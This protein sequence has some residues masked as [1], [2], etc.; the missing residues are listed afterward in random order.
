[1]AVKRLSSTA[2][3]PQPRDWGVP[4]SGGTI[5]GSGAVVELVYNDANFPPTV[6]GRERLA[7]AVRTLADRIATMPAS[8]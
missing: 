2:S 5:T 3:R 6:E 8:V 1:M 7:L 4:A